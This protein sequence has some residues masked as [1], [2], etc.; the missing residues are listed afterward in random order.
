[1]RSRRLWAALFVVLIIIVSNALLPHPPRP[2]ISLRAEQVPL[3][4][5]HIPNSIIA[6]WLAM[7]VLIGLSYAATRKME[8]VPGRLQTAVEW[9]VEGLYNLSLGIAGEHTRMVFPVAATLFLFILTANWM[10][11]LPGFGSVG[12]QAVEEGQQVFIPLL[13]SAA[14]D[15]N[16]TIALAI[17]AIAS[18]QVFGLRSLGRAYVSRFLNLKKV[19]GRGNLMERIATLFIG[20]L[21]LFDQFTKV[22]SFSFRLF[23]NTFAGEVLLLVIA[24]LL[25]II[26]PLPFMGLEIFLGF[27]QALIFALLTLVYAA[28]AAGHGDEHPHAPLHRETT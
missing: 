24:F 23:G 7:I 20:A 27:I 1:M 17:F 5:Q 25:P 12:I 9:A 26:G 4:G 8:W 13:R 2:E 6:T 15:L 16:T 11:L 18:I 10:E 3:F 28:E 19:L 22:L 21:E 14:T